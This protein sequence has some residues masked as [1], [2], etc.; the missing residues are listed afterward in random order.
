[1]INE[2][3]NKIENKIEKS[4]HITE[5]NKKEY[6]EMLSALRGEISEISEISPSDREKAETISGFAGI[7]A[8]EATREETNPELL[9]LSLD[10]LKK[11]VEGFEVSNP[12]LVSAVNSICSLLS[13]LGI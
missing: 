7:T 9:E 10:G 12:R 2:T 1:M 5:D 13:N 11:S 4:V 3:M 6:M 8:H